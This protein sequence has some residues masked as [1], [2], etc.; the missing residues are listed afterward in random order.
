MMITRVCADGFILGAS[1]LAP[2][3]S[4][5]YGSDF[6]AVTLSNASEMVLDRLRQFL[7]LKRHMGVNT[8]SPYN[9]PH[10]L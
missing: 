5:P 3:M 9:V 4:N 10:S 2:K 8:G 7:G 1:L 6:Q